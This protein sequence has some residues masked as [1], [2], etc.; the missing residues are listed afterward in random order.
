LQPRDVRFVF[1]DS[2]R[3]PPGEAPL[4]FL[5]E[6]SQPIFRDPDGRLARRLDAPSATE[7]FVFDAA[8]TLRYRGGLDDDR[9]YLRPAPR[10]FL[11]DELLSLLDGTAPLFV[12]AKTLGCAL[13]LR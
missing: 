7:T 9:T 1:V 5:A 4:D 6:A 3:H 10:N 11:R 8:G 13:R 2:E 12:A